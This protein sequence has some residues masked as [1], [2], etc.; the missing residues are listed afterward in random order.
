MNEEK[1]KLLKDF[2]SPSY[3]IQKGVSKPECFGIR[4][5]YN[6]NP[7]DCE[8]KKD[9]F[10]KVKEPIFVSFDGKEFF[11]GDDLV[12]RGDLSLMYY[13]VRAAVEHPNIKFFSIPELAKGHLKKNKPK[14]SEQQILDAIEKAGESYFDLTWM[15]ELKKELGIC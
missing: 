14:F 4:I 7:G 13:R 15:S 1:Y 8:I 9:W 12:Y 6:L 10:E 5:F 3:H 11:D 2:N